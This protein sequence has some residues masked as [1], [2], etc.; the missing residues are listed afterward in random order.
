M[1]CLPLQQLVLLPGKVGLDCQLHCPAH[2]ENIYKK[3]FNT[4]NLAPPS[5]LQPVFC[6]EILRL[7]KGNVAMVMVMV[8][9]GRGSILISPAG[10]HIVA[11]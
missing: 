1:I 4:I 2:G 3:K 9:G 5:R 7:R 6:S 10:A 11:L 8:A